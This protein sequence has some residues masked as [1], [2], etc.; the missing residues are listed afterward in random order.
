MRLKIAVSVVRFR[1]WAPSDQVVGKLGCPGGSRFPESGL[2]AL[3]RLMVFGR[4]IR[5]AVA[6]TD[7]RVLRTRDY[8]DEAKELGTG[9]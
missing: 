7:C 9:R 8:R 3:Y 6:L 2:C 5:F 1:P 4:V